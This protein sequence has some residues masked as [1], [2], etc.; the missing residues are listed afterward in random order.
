MSRLVGVT[1]LPEYFQVEGVDRVLDNLVQRAGVNAIAMSPYVMQLADE[2]TGSREPP[3]DAGAGKVRQLDR[4]L[5]GRRELWVRTSPSFSPNRDYYQDLRYQPPTPDDLTAREGAIVQQ[6]IEAAKQRGLQVYFQVQAAIPPGYR[7]Q[8]GGPLEADQPRMPDGRTPANRVANNASLASP[9]V[10][11]YQ[12][13]LIRDLHANYPDIDGIRFDWPEYPPYR[14]DSM[15]V[16]FSEHAERFAVARGFD[17]DAFN[18]M[19]VDAAKL[20]RLLHGGLDNDAIR[21][22]WN[23]V[24]KATDEKASLLPGLLAA[25]PGVGQMLE[26]KAEMSASLL[27]GFRQEM[28]RVSGGRWRLAPSAFPPPWSQIS[29]FNFAACKDCC[30]AVGVKLYGMH[31]AMMLRFYGES[32]LAANPSL[33]ERLLVKLLAA[34]LGIADDDGLSTLEDYHYPEPDEPHPIGAQSQQRKLH[35]AQTQAGTVPVHALAHAY[36][37]VEDVRRRLR[38]AWEAGPHGV[39]VN[40]Y[41]YLSDAKLDA[42]GACQA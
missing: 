18:A 38:T 1:V 29:G 3:I 21:S 28:D 12:H 17:Q 26:L 39:W 8:F 5:W 15:F 2:A 34:L 20:Y 16:D 32:L 35:W 19:R 14:L 30:H 11:A 31:W 37:P 4:P 27:K 9:D 33:D 42:L 22:Q 6:A 13:A 23:A 10:I 25:F 24:R 40:R 7:V 36:G 41:C